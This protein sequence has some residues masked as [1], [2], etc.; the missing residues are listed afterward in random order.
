MSE[1]D[2]IF[3]GYVKT[4]TLERGEEGNID[5]KE[6]LPVVSCN[7]NRGE[8]LQGLSNTEYNAFVQ[9]REKPKGNNGR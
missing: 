3:F 2:N 1:D 6:A 5:I 9:V 8:R 7:F 4:F